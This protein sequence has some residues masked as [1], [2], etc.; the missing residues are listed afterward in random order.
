[1]PNASAPQV[2]SNSV[3]APATVAATP[4][5]TA[6]ASVP[7][8]APAVKPPKM[9]PPSP[10]FDPK[11]PINW[12][13]AQPGG[14]PSIDELE[15][16]FHDA[17]LFVL[18]T[19]VTGSREEVENIKLLIRHGDELTPHGM[20]RLDWLK[21]VADAIGA[22]NPS[23][24]IEERLSRSL[25]MKYN[26][27]IYAID[28]GNYEER[29]INTI[30]FSVLFG[31]M[32]KVEYD[33]RVGCFFRYRENQGIWEA[34]AE[35]RVRQKLVEHMIPYA[36]QNMEIYNPQRSTFQE[37][38]YHLKAL[39]LHDELMLKEKN[40]VA[41]RNGVVIIGKSFELYPHSWTYKLRNAVEM[42]FDP[43]R[44]TPTSFLG[45]LVAAGLSQKDIE[46]L[47]FWCGMVLLGINP[48]HKIM[49]IQGVAGSGKSTLI[50]IIEKIIGHV[51]VA[52]L[53]TMRL[54]ERFELSEFFGKTLLVGK[55]VG[56]DFMS[57]KSSHMLKSLSG[58]S[59]LKAEV[60]FVQARVRLGGPFNIALTTNLKL[61]VRLAGDAD[62][63]ERR[64]W[65]LQFTNAVPEKDRK[66]NF[67]ERLIE[68]EGECILYWMLL[69]AREVLDTMTRGSGSFQMDDIQK[70]RVKDLLFHSNE[71]DAFVKSDVIASSGSELTT[72][73]L[74]VAYC[75]YC[76][77]N[78]KDAVSKTA[79]SHRIGVPLYENYK[80]QKGYATSPTGVTL[81]GY[82]NIAFSPAIV[83]ALAG[84]GA[85]TA[86]ST[87]PA[88]TPA[89]G[90]SAKTG[91]KGKPKGAV[92][93]ASGAV[94]AVASNGAA[95]GSHSAS[96][97]A[98]DG[99]AGAPARS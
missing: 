55:D 7:A 1:M 20:T 72:E 81:R 97:S 63:W 64:L 39:L 12:L 10:L 79:F 58:D 86:T 88:A 49:I 71:L 73:E 85:A 16:E 35:E 37:I 6:P 29:R 69:G 14:W 42:N 3:A 90:S 27:R 5:A 46:M 32:L 59:G 62:A 45:M 13:N 93:P 80:S 25:V 34:T 41:V 98:D 61:R 96:D 8:P 94:V 44:K 54:E 9:G 26:K 30:H 4:S 75:N 53:S 77:R 38:L 95:N 50:N 43:A 89:S 11:T 19:L 24:P 57:T 18:A 84:A 23:M 76:A 40:R 60:K 66:P 48:F 65:I 87:A 67:D 78:L 52:T 15:K 36:D 33:E 2:T 99:S 56:E 68:N 47:Q 28:K 83:A 70:K 51:N 91:G 31:L 74:Y 92:A 21:E 17:T 82:S 22:R